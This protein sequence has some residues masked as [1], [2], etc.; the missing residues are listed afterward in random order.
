MERINMKVSTKTIQ[1]IL[2]K[3]ISYYDKE[4]YM[5]NHM[6]KVYGF[7]RNIAV[8]ED[9]DESKLEILEIGSI[10]HDIGIKESIK[11]Y[12]S[13]AGKYQEIEGPPIAREW[14]TEFGL[15]EG[16]IDRVCFLIGHHHSYSFIDD[17][18]FQILV[19]ADFLVNIHE[20][21]MTKEQIIEI[22]EKYFK[23]NTG[24]MILDSMY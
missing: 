3:Y 10:L 1:Q 11:K 2:N 21:E 6:L 18:D 23:T 17:I 7:A 22:R 19:E 14:L 4:A 8:L 13:G 12:G 15:E 24:R 9:L 16:L 20:N 5:T